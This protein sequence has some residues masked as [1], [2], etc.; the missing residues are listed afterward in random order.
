ML[1]ADLYSPLLKGA[2]ADGWYLYRLPDDS[3]FPRPFDFGGFAPGG[4]GVALEVKLVGQ[5][6]PRHRFPWRLFSPHQV[7]WLVQ[8]EALGALAV[9]GVYVAESRSM[10]LYYPC[11]YHF[12]A[13]TTVGN[14]PY[15]ELRREHDIFRGWRT[16]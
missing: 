3:A 14:V 2:R 13:D 16:L 15:V 5:L 6:D 4:R 10:R 1:E 8:A 12:G 7:G 9:A 11:A